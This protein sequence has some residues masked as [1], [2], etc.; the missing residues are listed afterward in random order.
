MAQACEGIKVLDFSQGMAG[1]IAT[2]FLCDNGAEVIKIEPPAG[3]RDRARPAFLQW[4]RGK[5]SVVLDLK[6]SEG[7]ETAH[8]LARGA[9]AVLESFRP[10]VADRLGIG[11]EAL[12]KLNE[13][14][15]YCSITG[16]GPKGAYRNI[17]G[18]DAVVAA[19]T[20]RMVG[21]NCWKRPGPM[22]DAIPRMSYGAAHLAVQG[23]LAALW[24]REKT[25]RGQPVQTRLV[26]DATGH[27]L[28]QLDR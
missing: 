6:T 15:V 16:F 2:M 25:G 13:S 27:R 23:I 24:A 22:F 14:M 21:Q 7:V 5:K 3:D 17:K 12:R 1:A 10:G 28:G 9:D 18:Y 4:A 20:G 11:Y 8:R 26:Q 19:K